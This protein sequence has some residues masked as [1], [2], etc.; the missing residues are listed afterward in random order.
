MGQASK[1]LPAWTEMR[2]CFR[3]TS[4][5]LASTPGPLAA[6]FRSLDIAARKTFPAVL[7]CWLLAAGGNHPPMRLRMPGELPPQRQCRIERC[8]RAHGRCLVL[9]ARNQL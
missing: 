2:S 4:L 3:A 7:A 5:Q 6:A 1:Y 8:Q 9:G